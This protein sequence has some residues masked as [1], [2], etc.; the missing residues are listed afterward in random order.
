MRACPY[1]LSEAGG[2]NQILLHKGEALSIN[3]SADG[4]L[5]MMPHTPGHQQIFEVYVP[6]P[7]NKSEKL[8]LVEVRWARQ[9][10]QEAKDSMSLVGVKFLMRPNS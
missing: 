4:M 9:V 2:S 6:S 3:V 10:L 5:L 8:T 1:E 7:T